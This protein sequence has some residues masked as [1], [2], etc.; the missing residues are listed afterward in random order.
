MKYV[1]ILLRRKFEHFR[2]LDVEFLKALRISFSK[3]VR[4]IMWGGLAKDV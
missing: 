2:A 1:R 4:I 3:W